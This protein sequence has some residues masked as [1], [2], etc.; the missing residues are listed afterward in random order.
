MDR[1]LAA[2]WNRVKFP[3]ASTNPPQEQLDE[4]TKPKLEGTS[5]PV[6]VWKASQDSELS[7][8]TIYES[9]FHVLIVFHRHVISTCA[10]RE[11][12]KA[13]L[14]QSFRIPLGTRR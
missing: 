9:H 12:E 10:Q 1:D 11:S 5:F 14:V 2:V 6:T 13:A 3:V 4:L 8:M 7:I